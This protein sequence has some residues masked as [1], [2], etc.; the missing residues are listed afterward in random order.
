PRAHAARV[1]APAGLASAAPR[2]ARLNCWFVEEAGGGGSV[3]PSALRQRPALL[4]LPPPGRRLEERDLE[5]EL[6]PEV[7][8]GLAFQILG[9]R[10]RPPG[11]AARPGEGA[12]GM[13]GG[14]ER[15]G[16]GYVQE[17]VGAA[18][19]ALGGP[20]GELAPATTAGAPGGGQ[21][22]FSSAS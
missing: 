6:P 18:G 22:V 15:G 8:S 9:R 4:L 10:R 11:L 14:G 17:R 7:E 16:A 12:P 3:M 21:R 5:P 1:F 20:W 19:G 2:L 13:P